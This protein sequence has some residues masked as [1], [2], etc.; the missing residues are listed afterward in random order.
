M[1]I[2]VT[3]IVVGVLLRSIELFR[4]PPPWLRR[5]GA[6][7]AS[8]LPDLAPAPATP[9]YAQ[10][11]VVDMNVQ[12]GLFTRPFIQH[13]LAALDRELERLDRDPDVFAKAFHT[14][15]ARSAYEALAA[16]AR[17]LAE[18]SVHGEAGGLEFELMGPSS[19]RREE[20]EI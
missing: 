1:E 3:A 13:R 5:V 11:A 14:I 18:S 16:D 2:F 9:Q 10:G 8:R 17:R 20:I 6:V 4:S 7:L 12:W 15:A 19:G